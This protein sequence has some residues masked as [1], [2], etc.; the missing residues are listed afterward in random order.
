MP[1]YE[2]FCQDCNTVFNF[3]SRRINTTKIPDC[4]KCGRELKKMLSSFATVGKAKEGG[5]EDLPPGFDESRMEKA[6]GELAREAEQMNEEDPKAMAGLMRKFSEK[7]GLELNENMEKALSRLEAGEDPDQI[8][9]EM[10]DVF[11][12]EDGLPFEFRQAGKGARR[13]APIH[14]ETLYEM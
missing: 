12:G 6:L 11:E 14:D 5:E 9:K 7:T 3:Y 2:F 1:I 8:E 13:K 10:G 4:P